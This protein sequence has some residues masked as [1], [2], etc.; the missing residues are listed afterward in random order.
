MMVQT[1]AETDP[2]VTPDMAVFKNRMAKKRA[3]DKTRKALRQH[4]VKKLKL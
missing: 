2:V 3:V 4:Q 1:E